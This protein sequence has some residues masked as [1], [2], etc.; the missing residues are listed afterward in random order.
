[1]SIAPET[2]TI[3]MQLSLTRTALLSSLSMM[4]AYH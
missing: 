3:H 1:M 2:T 4:L